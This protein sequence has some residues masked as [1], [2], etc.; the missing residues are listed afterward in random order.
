MAEAAV[1][2]NIRFWRWLL[3]RVV[4]GAE[5]VESPPPPDRPQTAIRPTKSRRG[6][7]KGT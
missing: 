7:R 1:P 5:G 3:S 6:T 4:A 2:D